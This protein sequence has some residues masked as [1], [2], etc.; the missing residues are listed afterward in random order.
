M[1]RPKDTGPGAPVNCPRCGRLAAVLVRGQCAQCLREEHDQLRRVQAY[2]AQAGPA[3]AEE[4]A[5]QTGV[6]VERVLRW[7]REGRLVASGEAF[8]CRR[9]GRPVRLGV[10]CAV[11]RVELAVAI[12]QLEEAL[13][14]QPPAEPRPRRRR[15][16]REPAPDRFDLW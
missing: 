7:F 1:T 6:P 14:S 3:S 11:C 4:I 13:R 12:R 2:L 16:R 5:E 9:C 10:L 8:R 15:L